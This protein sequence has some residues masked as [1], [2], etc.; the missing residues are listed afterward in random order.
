MKL[1]VISGLSGS[2]KSIA[3]ESLEDFGFYCIDN[4]PIALL[5]VFASQMVGPTSKRFYNQAAVG[6]DARN[7]HEDLQHFPKILSEIAAAGIECEVVFLVANNETLLKRFSETRR[8]HPLTRQD[9]SLAE[10]IRVE[11]RLL[12]PISEH[13]SLQIDTS[14]TNVHQLRELIRE[15]VVKHQSPSLSLLFLSFGYKHG[16]PADADFVFDVRCLPNPN[17]VPNLRQLTGMDA[18]V[19][20]FL[21]QQ[22]RFT[23]MYDE[24]RV[25]LGN[26]IPCFESENR[27]YMTTAIGCTGGQHRSVYMVELMAAYFRTLRDNV[28]S[29]HRE[30]S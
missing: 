3:L 22:P 25:F 20:Q 1:V 27:T 29:R 12:A 2:G 24:L 19:R 7:H 28:L 4:L 6:I 11:R 13:A 23:K 18:P 15:R 10:A 9:V 21:D 26:W 14:S 8:K 30:L 5:P 16:V 17:W